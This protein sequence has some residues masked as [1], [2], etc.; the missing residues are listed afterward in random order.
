MS[1]NKQRQRY[2]LFFNFF[3]VF[4]K[5]GQKQKVDELG[6]HFYITWVPLDWTVARV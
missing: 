2:I 6:R 4:K 1:H 5:L 3:W